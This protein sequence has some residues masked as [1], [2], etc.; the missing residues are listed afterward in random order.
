RLHQTVVVE[1]RGGAGG[2]IA[3]AA[4]VRAAPDGYTLLVTT[5]A[6][7]INETLHETKPFSIADLKTVAIGASSPESLI[8]STDNPAATLADFVKEAKAKGQPI[9]F[10]AGGGGRRV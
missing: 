2:N 1:N 10:S 3:A 6:L 7:A 8:T 9:T 5:T 4:A